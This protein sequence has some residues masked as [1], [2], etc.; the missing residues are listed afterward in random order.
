M[1]CDDEDFFLFC[2]R[3]GRGERVRQGAQPRGVTGLH[4]VGVGLARRRCRVGVAGRSRA[5]VVLDD[6]QGVGL[7]AAQYLITSDGIIRGVRP[8][9]KDLTCRTDGGARHVDGHGQRQLDPGGGFRPRPVPGAGGVLAVGVTCP[10][11][12]V[13]VGIEVE[14]VSVS[15]VSVGWSFPSEAVSAGIVLGALGPVHVVVRGVGVWCCGG[16]P[17]DQELAGFVG[18]PECVDGSCWR[19]WVI[20]GLLLDRVC[21]SRLLDRFRGGRLGRF[22]G[23]G[24]G[25]SGPWATPGFAFVFAP[26]VAST[27]ADLVLGIVGEVRDGGGGRRF[28]PC[29]RVR[30]RPS[31]T[32]SLRW[33]WP[34]QLR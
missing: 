10:H 18:G 24:D 33:T 7:G 6:H 22:S 21:F 4:G 15:V 29:R 31:M 32:G 23:Y 20:P 16:C 26:V 27:H 19:V 12:N 9:Q 17:G 2:R 28:P 13:V 11:A 30:R 1:P 25:G 34:S 8:K 3:H 14:S 5:G